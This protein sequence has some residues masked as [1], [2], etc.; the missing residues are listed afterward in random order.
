M[1]QQTKPGVDKHVGQFETVTNWWVQLYQETI[2]QYLLKMNIPCDPTILLLGIY[3]TNMYTY[4][5]VKAYT[6][7][8]TAALFIIA[9]PIQILKF[10]YNRINK[11]HEIG[12]CNVV[13]KI[14]KNFKNCNNAE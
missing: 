14:N 6:R 7:I 8:F 1:K 5:H 10:T 3:L 2:W 12:L 11:P 9:T 4:I 13:T